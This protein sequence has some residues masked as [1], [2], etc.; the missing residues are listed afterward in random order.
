MVYF[1][2][3]HFYHPPKNYDLFYFLFFIYSSAFL[4]GLLPCVWTND[5][6]WTVRDLGPIYS[7]LWDPFATVELRLLSVRCCRHLIFLSYFRT[8]S[9]IF[10]VSKFFR[11]ML[12]NSNPSSGVEPKSFRF[13][14][15]CSSTVLAW[16]KFFWG[17]L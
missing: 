9:I 17:V 2:W 12:E 16:K 5:R 6:A 7:D 10:Y 8:S 3:K 4:W 13:I 15:W 1:N 14:V 11:F